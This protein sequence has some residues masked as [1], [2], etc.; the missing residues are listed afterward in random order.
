MN[1]YFIKFSQKIVQNSMYFLYG[2]L[3]IKDFEYR[4]LTEG[5]IKTAKKVFHNLINYDEVKI[6]NIP[7]LPWQPIN[8]LMAPNG[9][10][11]V[12]KE[13]FC[14]DYSK[15]SVTTQGI[16]IHELAHILQ[17]QKHKN[18]VLRGFLLQSA[19]YLSLKTYNPY[20]YHL[21]KGKLFEQYNI[22]QQGEIARDIFLEKIPNIIINS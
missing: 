4:K 2:W 14:K 6:F 9:R 21:I 20:K 10:L 11:F 5:E 19:Y 18:V 22:E 16:F 8:I 1:K 7:Y 15:C 3:N 17:Y 13:I 12:N